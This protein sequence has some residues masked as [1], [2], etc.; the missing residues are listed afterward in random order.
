MGATLV[1]SLIS[2][3]CGS[4]VTA[5]GPYSK[6]FWVALKKKSRSQHM[7]R[8]P[9][10]QEADRKGLFGNRQTNAHLLRP[11]FGQQSPNGLRFCSAPL[12][13]SL[14]GGPCILRS[15]VSVTA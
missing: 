10:R 14:V 7:G 8:G 13:P 2:T 6:R 5:L 3:T 11:L 1:L 12:L 15:L 4:C 9:G